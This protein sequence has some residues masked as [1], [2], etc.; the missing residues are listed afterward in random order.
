M[1]EGSGISVTAEDVVRMAA[2]IDLEI[3]PG[4]EESVA[5]GLA[6]HLAATRSLLDDVPSETSPAPRFDPSW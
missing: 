4:D 2:M 5:A 6:A 3:T 1:D